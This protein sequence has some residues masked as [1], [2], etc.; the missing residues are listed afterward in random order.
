M[1]KKND[2]DKQSITIGDFE[3]TMEKKI[4]TQYHIGGRTEKVKYID[5][6][7]HRKSDGVK[8]E[9]DTFSGTLD[10]V[11]EEGNP[12]SLTPYVMMVLRKTFHK[13]ETSDDSTTQYYTD[14]PVDYTGSIPYSTLRSSPSST[15]VGSRRGILRRERDEEE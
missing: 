4:L 7:I 2:K 9:I 3:I 1:A 5:I 11:D 13:K 10:I 6:T 8:V 14:E 12:L 15:R